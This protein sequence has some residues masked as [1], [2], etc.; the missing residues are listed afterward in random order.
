MS[1]RV[2]ARAGAQCRLEGVRY[3][4]R[5]SSEPAASDDE[6]SYEEALGLEDAAPGERC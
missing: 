6:E 3:V 1:E 4:E 2:S 5:G